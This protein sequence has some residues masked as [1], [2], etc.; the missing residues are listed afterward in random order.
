MSAT[1]PNP[2][3]NL[4]ATVVSVHEIDL[5][6]TNNNPGFEAGIDRAHNAGAGH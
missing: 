2:V 3:T 6:W 5:A 4:T 1:Q